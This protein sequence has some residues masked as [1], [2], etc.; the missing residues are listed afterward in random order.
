MRLSSY[1]VV[2]Q[3]RRA[4]IQDWTP[5]SLALEPYGEALGQVL[6]RKESRGECIQFSRIQ[7]SPWQRC[8]N[9]RLPGYITAFIIHEWAYH[10][11]SCENVLPRGQ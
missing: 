9:K 6:C 8:Q 7:V 4:G 3:L 1:S 5:G 2:T 11:H 10:N